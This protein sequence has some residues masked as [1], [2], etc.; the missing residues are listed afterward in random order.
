MLFQAIS[1]ALPCETLHWPESK[2]FFGVNS[3][4][5]GCFRGFSE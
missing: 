5:S 4:A 1:E 3:L 2:F